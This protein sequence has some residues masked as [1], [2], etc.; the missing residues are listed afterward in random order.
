VP[1]TYKISLSYDKIRNIDTHEMPSAAHSN[2]YVRSSKYN[3]IASDQHM[4]N[5]PEFPMKVIISKTT[6]TLYMTQETQ[7]IKLIQMKCTHTILETLLASYIIL[8][9]LL[10]LKQVK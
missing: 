9:I 6:A 7:K 1:E 8:H 2:E 4:V 3:V 5:D 10:E